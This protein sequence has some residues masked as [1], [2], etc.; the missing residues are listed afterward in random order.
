MMQQEE[1]Q[2]RFPLISNRIHP[3]TLLTIKDFFDANDCFS[4]NAA[5]TN[6]KI[7]ESILAGETK[8]I[9][10]LTRLDTCQFSFFC[11][12]LTETSDP[13]AMMIASESMKKLNKLL[14]EQ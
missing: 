13:I 4:M 6:F 14:L 11:L 2:S 7:M 5:T 10:K 3:L 8:F 9:T 1:L 12:K